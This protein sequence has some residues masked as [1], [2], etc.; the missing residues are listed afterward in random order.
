M[1]SPTAPPTPS[2]TLPIPDATAP[3]PR[4]TPP[5]IAPKAG[6]IFSISCPFSI[7][8]RPRT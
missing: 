4:A 8:S 3:T 7:G 1:A 6:I 5:A 2:T